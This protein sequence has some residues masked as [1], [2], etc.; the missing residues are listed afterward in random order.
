[1][2]REVG[3]W[4]GPIWIPVGAALLRWRYGWRIV[5]RESRAPRVPRGSAQESSAPLLV[6]ANHLT[7]V[8]SFLI[9]VALASP[10]WYVRALRGA[11]VEHARARQLLAHLVA[12]DRAPT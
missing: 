3:R 5:D 4:L 1:M 10:W 8:D 6:C 9:A 11:A 7:M 12:A 2:Q